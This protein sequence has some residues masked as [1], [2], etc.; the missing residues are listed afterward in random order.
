MGGS[1]ELLRVRLPKMS[2]SLLHQNARETPPSL[3]HTPSR[4]AFSL[5]LRGL[6]SANAYETNSRGGR[7]AAAGRTRAWT[8]GKVGPGTKAL[9]NLG[10]ER[11]SGQMDTVGL[12]FGVFF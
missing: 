5:L 2:S 12:G 11:T 7:G 1:K 6:V 10:S 3:P 8:P 9:R 4:A